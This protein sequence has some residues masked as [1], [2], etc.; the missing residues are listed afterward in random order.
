MT[1]LA[2]Y[3]V[4]CSAQN[5]LSEVLGRPQGLPG[6][7]PLAFLLCLKFGCY[8]FHG[9]GLCGCYFFNGGGLCGCGWRRSSETFHHPSCVL[10]CLSNWSSG[11]VISRTVFLSTQ[12]LG[13]CVE[14]VVVA[15]RDGER[16]SE[17]VRQAPEHFSFPLCSYWS[18]I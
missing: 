11:K 15:R 16:P 7:P 13:T 5:G 17:G 14:G 12:L 18:G 2:G 6:W 10:R 8:F 1:R 4:A 9:G 3:N